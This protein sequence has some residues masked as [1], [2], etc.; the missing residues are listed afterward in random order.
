MDFAFSSDGTKSSIFIFYANLP[1]LYFCSSVL[2]L[3][4][5]FILYI[6]DNKTAIDVT[7]VQCN[8]FLE[9]NVVMGVGGL[10]GNFQKGYP[11]LV[12]VLIG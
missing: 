7:N 8:K 5:G 1:M 10:L 6:F 12:L 11:S 4:G 9:S 2:K 3:V